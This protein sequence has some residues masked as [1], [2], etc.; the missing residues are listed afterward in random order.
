MPTASRFGLEQAR[1]QLPAIVAQASAGFTS[2]ITRHGKSY[3]AVISIEQLPQSAARA[4]GGTSILALQGTGRGLWGISP[5]RNSE[6]VTQGMGRFLKT[7]PGLGLNRGRA[8]LLGKKSAYRRFS[9]GTSAQ[10]LI[11]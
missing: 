6:R 10:K 8:S 2:V 9:M 11:R 4:N 1:I 3:A 5:R 7:A